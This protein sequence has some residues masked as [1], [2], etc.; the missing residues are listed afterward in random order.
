MSTE[1]KIA[2]T[3]TEEMQ[4]QDA[5]WNDEKEDLVVMEKLYE[6]IIKEA[7]EKGFTGATYIYCVS[8]EMLCQ[9]FANEEEKKQATL[10]IFEDYEEVGHCKPLIRELETIL[11]G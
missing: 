10:G 2:L 8:G 5:L 7:K 6:A 1:S 11:N 9:I 4:V 3:Y